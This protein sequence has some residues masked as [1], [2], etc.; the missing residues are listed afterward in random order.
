MREKDVCGTHV[1]ELLQRHNRQAVT[2]LCKAYLTRSLAFCDMS[3]QYGSGNVYVALMINENS[4]L[5]L[6]S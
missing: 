6:S 5:L 1:L 4:F 2:S 3:V